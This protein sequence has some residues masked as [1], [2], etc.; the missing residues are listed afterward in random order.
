MGGTVPVRTGMTKVGLPGA[1]EGWQ[2][3]DPT[4]AALLKEQGLRDR[5]VRQEP[6]RRPR[7]AP[8]DDARLRRVFRQPLPPQRVGGARESRLPERSRVPQ[9]VRPARRPQGKADGRGGQTIEDTG[10]L[11]KKRMETIDDET[12]RRPNGLH[13]PQLNAGTPFFCWWNGTRMHFR[14]HVKAENRG[15]S[16]QDEYA[17]GMVEH[18][19]H[20]RRVAQVA[21][22]SRHRQQHHRHVLDRQRPALQCLAGCRHH[23]VP[24][25]EELQLGGRLSGA[26]IRALARPLPGRETL[27]GLVAHEDWLPTFLARGRHAGHQGAAL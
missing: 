25:R 9:E 6:L 20:G 24:Q 23:A 26:G 18:D 8:A 4:I 2:K 17:D 16:G 12:S 15:K 1:K 7:R 19:A 22:R 3:S 21:R 13:H 5:P 14:T 10:P 27:N 11:T